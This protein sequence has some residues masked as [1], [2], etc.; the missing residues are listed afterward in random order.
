MK[1]AGRWCTLIVRAGNEMALVAKAKKEAKN[2]IACGAAADE[3]A[4]MLHHQYGIDWN[5]A[6]AQAKTLHMRSQ[7]PRW[8]W[9]FKGPQQ[10]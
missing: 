5:V 9:Y 1:K 2:M 10:K 6:C 7:P 3:I 4:H 8:S